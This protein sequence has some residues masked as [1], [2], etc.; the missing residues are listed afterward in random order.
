MEITALWREILLELP[1]TKGDLI[2]VKDNYKNRILRNAENALTKQ[3]A[4]IVRLVGQLRQLLQENRRAYMLASAVGPSQGGATGLTELEMDQ[5]DGSAHEIFLK[6]T[7]L[8]KAFS[9]NS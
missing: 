3:S 9:A 2:N 1:E 5:I 4:S 8:I 6:C 7:E